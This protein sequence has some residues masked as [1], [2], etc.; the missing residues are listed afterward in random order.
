V[1]RKGPAAAPVRRSR[2]R[3]WQTPAEQQRRNPVGDW[4]LGLGIATVVAPIAL[5]LLAAPFVAGWDIFGVLLA[6]GILAC[7]L[8]IGAVLLGAVG[9]T[10]TESRGRSALTAAWGLGLGLLALTLIFGAL[11]SLAH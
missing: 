9:L 7:V 1:T 3:G 10:T 5:V 6:A 8:A 4:A 11:L 2:R